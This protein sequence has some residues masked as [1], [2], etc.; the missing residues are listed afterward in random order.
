[1][2]R[3]LKL[4]N[5]GYDFIADEGPDGSIMSCFVA[6]FRKSKKNSK[7]KFENSAATRNKE[8]TNCSIGAMGF[9]LFHRFQIFG[10][11]WPDFT[12]RSN[13]F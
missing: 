5:L 6:T 8:V 7:G 4:S 10:D 12:K 2:T 13:Q 11:V 3:I 1:M 9:Y